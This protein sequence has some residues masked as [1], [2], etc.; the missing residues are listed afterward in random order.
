VLITVLGLTLLLGLLPIPQIRTL[1]LAVQSTLTATVGDSFAFVE[2]PI[3]AALIRECI[4]DGL[5][6]LKPLCVHT[7]VVAHSQGAAVVLDAL[8]AL[9]QSNEKR[10]VESA[11]RLVP[12]ALITFG[13]GTNQLASQ[14]VL[15]DRIPKMKRNPVLVA[16][17]AI[18]GAAGA[19]GMS[20]WLYWN[21]TVPA[22]LWGGVVVLSFFIM[23]QGVIRLA[24]ARRRKEQRKE[25]GNTRE[26][27]GY[28][29]LGS[30]RWW[31]QQYKQKQQYKELGNNRANIDDLW[32]SF[33]YIAALLAIGVGWQF[34][35]NYFQD[36]SR[37]L[38]IVPISWL[39]LTLIFLL[40]SI[41]FILSPEGKRIIQAPVSRPM[42]LRR[43]VDLYASADPVPNG[44]TRTTEGEHESKRISNLGSLLRDHTA[45][46]DNRDGFVLRVA[47]VCAETAESP[48]THALPDESDFIDKRAAWRVG[49]L[50]AARW[51]SGLTWLALGVLLWKRNL[52]NVPILPV[53]LPIWVPASL[54]QHAVFLALIAL[55]I[56]ATSSALVWIWRWWV[57]AEQEVVL[58]HEQPGREELDVGKLAIFFMALVVSMLIAT[59]VYVYFF[60]RS[61][62]HLGNLEALDL[63]GALGPSLLFA[64]LCTY[65]PRVLKCPPPDAWLGKRS[66]DVPKLDRGFIL[67]SRKVASVLAFA[68]GLMLFYVLFYVVCFF[69]FR[70][71]LL[72]PMAWNVSTSAL[73]AEQEQALKPG[74]QF[75]ECANCPDM[76]VVPAGDFRMGSPADQSGGK[77][78][79]GPQHKVTIR[80]Q[81]AVGKFELTLNEWTACAAHGGCPV[82]YSYF[83][84]ELS[85][86]RSVRRPARS[87]SWYDAQRYV[88]WIVKVTGKPYRLLTEAEWEYAARGGT[89]TAYSWGDEIG[90][91]NA[92]CTGCGSNWLIA[93]VGSFAA[94]KYGLHDMHGNV[95]EWVEDCAHKSYE[96]NPPTDGSAWTAEG[97]CNRRIARGGSWSS[98]PHELRSAARGSY[99]KGDTASNVGFRIGRTLTP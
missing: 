13:A 22:I 94:N 72:H 82:G 12:D 85:F 56:W 73:T 60:I 48:W 81:F 52:A 51:I 2:S 74:D 11:W 69:V 46:W 27:D 25:P 30:A 19:A 53:D 47:R 86:W 29:L 54:F 35:V 88:A 17:G 5:E 63:I 62:A 71:A 75:T 9:E 78:S 16:V 42:K 43:W 32:H 3:R 58:G 57:L 6:R 38:P 59:V 93:P 39:L 49:F 7:V 45:Y 67:L 31:K 79:E 80:Q 15:T 41:A 68:G 20:L 66:D 4:L 97:D 55:G 65:L 77:S 50:Q 76:V 33:P 44:R 40:G 18:V 87:V 95:W 64:W 91:G 61:W 84:F 89:T 14:K 99:Y 28:I 1:A 26:D 21:A 96:G 90:K 10:E 98:D 37:Y 23:T 8:G 24:W 83:D 36:F 92:N 34:L 70:L